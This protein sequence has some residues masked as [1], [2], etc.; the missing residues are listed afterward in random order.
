MEKSMDTAL[1]GESVRIVRMAHDKPLYR[2][3]REIGWTANALACILL[4]APLG[5]PIAV[6]V[7]GSVFAVRKKDLK[8][9]LVRSEETQSCP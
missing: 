3:L 1:Q 9:I 8:E 7:N 6:K 4:P 5:D 2:R